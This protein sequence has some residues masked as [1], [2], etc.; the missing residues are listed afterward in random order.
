MKETQQLAS[1]LCT[2]QTFLCG[3]AV[4]AAI[5]LTFRRHPRATTSRNK[6]IICTHVQFKGGIMTYPRKGGLEQPCISG[7]LQP[8]PIQEWSYDISHQ[9]LDFEQGI[10][11]SLSVFCDGMGVPLFTPRSLNFLDSWT[12]HCLHVTLLQGVKHQ[13]DYCWLII[14]LN[15]REIRLW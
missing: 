6:D 3:S 7:E 4:F 2:V 10:K 9:Q 11:K 8:C 15:P 1:A 5:L 12:M 13:P 14:K